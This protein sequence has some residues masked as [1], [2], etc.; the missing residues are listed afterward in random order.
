[1]LDMILQSKNIQLHP[2][3]ELP[4]SKLMG[5]LVNSNDYIGYFVEEEVKYYNLFKL[6]I[7]EQLPINSIGMIYRKNTMNLVTKNFVKI[8]LSNC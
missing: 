3:I 8:V 6:D 7:Q 5:D 4:D 1:M 2:I